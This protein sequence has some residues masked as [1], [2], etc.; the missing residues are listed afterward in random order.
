[1]SRDKDRTD[2]EKEK[3][4]EDR[5]EIGSEAKTPPKARKTRPFLVSTSL[6][7]ISF[8]FYVAVAI[9]GL[10]AGVAWHYL[11]ATDHF[12]IS[13]VEDQDL[14]AAV[15]DSQGLV[16]GRIGNENRIFI[17]RSDLPDHFVDALIAAED[18]LYFFHPGVDPKGSL[19]AAWRNYR[20]SGIEEGGS[21]LTQQLARNVF[22]LEGRHME[23]KLIEMAVALRIELRY[24]KDEI[25]EHYLNRIY[26]GSGFYGLGSAAKGYFDKSVNELTL[27][28]SAMICGLIR[29]PSKSSPFAS[30]ELAMN[31]RNRT[32]DR[33][34]ASGALTSQERKEALAAK[35]KPVETRS[36]HVSRGQRDSLL[37]RVHKEVESRFPDVPTDGSTIHVSYDLRLQ[38]KAANL[39]DEH[40]TQISKN[41][42]KEKSETLQGAV[43]IL[44]RKTG[45]PLASVGS[46]DYLKTE[47]DRTIGM[48][49]PAGSAFLPLLYAA[50][51]EKEI[52][53]PDTQLLDGPL[54][55]RLVMLGG[56]EGV[57]GEWSTENPENTWEGPIRA[58][59][60]LTKSK[61]AASARLGFTL[62][63]NSLTNFIRQIGIKSDLRDRSGAFLGASEMSL[64]ELTHAYA[65][66]AE[67]RIIPA[68]DNAVRQIVDHTGAAVFEAPH[69]T[70]SVPLLADSTIQTIQ[71]SL[72]KENRE[73]V[74]YEKSGT[75]AG[76]TDA[77]HF[78]F[79]DTCI[80]GIWIGRDRFSSIAPRAFGNL[81]ARPVAEKLF[82]LPPF[83]FPPP[84][85]PEETL[86]KRQRPEFEKQYKPPSPLIGKDP[87][88]TL[89][90]AN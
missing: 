70:G 41:S 81:Y 55:N 73:S 74:F 36:V 45:L 6:F 51:Y 69:D 10:G 53:T 28:E 9:A 42:T 5:G 3:V 65:L 34:H 11:D 38:Q 60:A 62:G 61:N 25:L 40:L 17:Q 39:L 19:R 35:T 33:M 79:N 84:P 64:S 52:A 82:D 44:S 29:S 18:Q 8:V 1:M 59:D 75:T 30:Q 47:Y 57:L 54:D 63:L 76:Y 4:D 12:D 32:L 77:W 31:A 72:R 27:E 16:V 56:T 49:R 13:K 15:T 58:A 66:L 23:R 2:P 24:T 20:A 71:D 80:W 46:R 22:E 90:M 21:T 50:A 86:T 68:E 67:N 43:I 85:I 89:Q 26:F 88:G 14:G 83:E 37:D 78:G 7:L 48:K 87:F